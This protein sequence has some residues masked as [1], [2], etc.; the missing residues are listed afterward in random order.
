VAAVV[1]RIAKLTFAVAAIAM[2]AACAG[3]AKP[4][5]AGP[6][7]NA[8]STTIATSGSSTTSVPTAPARPATLVAVTAAGSVQALE[9][10]TGKTLRTLATGA[11]GDEITLTPDHANVFFERPTGC[12][13]QISRVALAGGP[14]ATV[15]VGSLPTVSPDGTRLAFARQPT[16]DITACQA[17]DVTAAAFSVVV[18]TIATGAETVFPLPPSVIANGLPLPISHLSW[19]PDGHRLAVT[20]AG[21]QDNEQ[22][23]LFMFDPTRDTYYAPNDRTDVPV[24]GAP[25][26]Y[27]REAVFT[28][29]GNLFV[30]REC[31]S[32]YPPKLTSSALALVDPVTG[33]TRKSVAIGLT[34]RDHNSLDSDDSGHW[35]LYLSGP[36]LLVSHDGAK[37]TTLATGFLAAAW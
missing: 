10:A 33:A 16:G 36:D 9:P 20:I 4:K 23:A 2:M 35:L 25:R 12:D 11:T 1:R 37:P 15:S 6:V 13:H 3:S 34:T 32:G 29:D 8:V 27:Y 14:A 17:A 18:R 19:A 22:W 28:P 30:D 21:G 26:S 31:C 24:V 5:A 7:S